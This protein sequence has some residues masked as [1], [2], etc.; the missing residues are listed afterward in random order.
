[1]TPKPVFTEADYDNPSAPEGQ[2]HI[3]RDHFEVRDLSYDRNRTRQMLDLYKDAL[4]DMG[5]DRDKIATIEDEELLPRERLEMYL[6]RRSRG[7]GYVS[8]FVYRSRDFPMVVYGVLVDRGRGLEVGELELFRMR[9]G[10]FDEWGSFVGEQHAE[11]QIDDRPLITPDLLRRLPLGRIIAMAQK[12]LAESDVED[13]DWDND[14]ETLASDGLERS[15]RDALRVATEGAK[16]TQRG[17]PRLGDDLLMSVAYAYLDEA[18]HG[19]GLIGRLAERF[20]RPEPTVRDWIAAA[21][22]EG[23]LT[24]GV[25][26][27]RGAGAGPRLPTRAKPGRS[28]G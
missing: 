9:W 16:R 2:R 13:P 24:Q 8:D 7:T 27:Q 5:W 26:G 21:R 22:R 10:H 6:K 19:V 3:R 1:M 14:E 4:I 11:P 28:G 15:S 20:D 23:F 17:R 25:R 18:A 12:S